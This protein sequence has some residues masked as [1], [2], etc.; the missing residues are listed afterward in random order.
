M[1]KALQQS[2]CDRRYGYKITEVEMQKMT[3]DF[4][5][6]SPVVC[7]DGHSP[8]PDD[9]LDRAN[10]VLAEVAKTG[11]APPSLLTMLR[12]RKPTEHYRSYY[13]WDQV[14]HFCFRCPAPTVNTDAVRFLQ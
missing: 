7:V 9:W 3:V 11:R 2:A 13:E 6:G 4:Y 14:R 10:Q 1:T 5:T 12:V 8:V